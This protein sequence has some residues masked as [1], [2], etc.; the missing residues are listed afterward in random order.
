MEIVR[1]TAWMP[2][3]LVIG[4]CTSSGPYYHGSLGYRVGDLGGLPISSS[5]GVYVSPRGV[6]LSPGVVI[7]PP[8]QK[9]AW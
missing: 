6:A 1:C 4:G 3:V 9:W 2:L 5:V 7:S 8:I